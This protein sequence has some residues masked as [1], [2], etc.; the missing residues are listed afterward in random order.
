MPWSHP[1]RGQLTGHHATGRRAGLR[2]SGRAA[3]RPPRP[4][5][6]AAPGGRPVAGAQGGDADPADERRPVD[7]ADG[8]VGPGRAETEAGHQGDADAGRDETLQDAVV[9]G[10]QDGH[11]GEAVGGAGPGEHSVDGV[12]LGGAE[13][14]AVLAEPGDRHPL[15]GGLRVVGGQDELQRV[16]QQ[17]VDDHVLAEVEGA[18]RPGVDEGDVQPAAAQAVE[19]RGQFALGEVDPDARAVQGPDGRRQ[20]Q[21]AGGGEGADPQGRRAAA[22][23]FA[24]LLLGDGDP[25][26]HGLGVRQEGG[27]GVGEDGA[28]GAA[29]HQRCAEVRLQGGQVVADGGL[30]VAE[31]AAG[32][33]ERAL[34]GDGPQDL[35]VAEFEHGYRR[36]L[37]MSRKPPYSSMARP[38]RPSRGEHR[39]QDPFPL[40]RPPRCGTAP[41]PV[42]GG[43]AAQCGR[44]PAAAERARPCGRSRPVPRSGGPGR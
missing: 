39:D 43:G 12:V 34:L 20:Q 44:R 19:Q 1:T 35:E 26:E 5:R 37:E 6:R 33:G 2:P 8:Q 4:A 27:P 14:P 9:V 32:R 36:F 3:G 15:G 7:G 23:E 29:V 31:G 38:V 41:R 42:R 13:D 21:R 16:V 24:D 17:R 30:A 40:S 18:V 10:A 11:G 25:A 22:D 28:A